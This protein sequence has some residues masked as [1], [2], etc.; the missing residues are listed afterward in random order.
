MRRRL[1]QRQ[2]TEDVGSAHSPGRSGRRRSLGD[3]DFAVNL[4]PN[5]SGCNASP[6]ARPRGRRLVGNYGAL[7]RAQLTAIF[8][9]LNA[10]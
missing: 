6:L 10:A 1:D 3:F 7:K 4:R 9:A 2:N 8:A 5:Q